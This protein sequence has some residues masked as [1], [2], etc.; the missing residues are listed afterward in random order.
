MMSA[1][2]VPRTIA[3]TG[4]SS[5]IGAALARRYAEPGAH[6]ILIARDLLRLEAVAGACRTRG[7]TTRVE[8]TDVRDPQAL[9]RTL[10]E[11]DDTTAIDL[12]IANAGI[13]IGNPGADD[14]EGLRDTVAQIETNLLGAI[15]TVSA[16]IEKMLTRRSG[17]IAFNASLSAFTPSPDWPGYCASKA[18]L[19]SYGLSLRERY[20]ARGIKVS[21]ICPG[22]VRA[23]INDQFEMWRPFEMS[24][25]HA[26]DIIAKGLARNK[27]IIA[28][29]WMLAWSARWVTLLPQVLR[30]I[31]ARLFR[32]RRRGA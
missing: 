31:G 28:F 1:R 30:Q 8:V 15:Y 12:L 7:A 22:W 5:G 6:L 3:I 25:E 18:G 16:V 13:L 29:P 19:L 11:I 14:P 17:Q 21:V 32:A 24:A 4:A 10:N 23:P 2:P 20:R 26:A 27:A 9:L